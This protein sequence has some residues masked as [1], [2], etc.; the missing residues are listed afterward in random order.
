MEGA[1][2]T[3][4]CESVV[5]PMPIAGPLTAATSGLVKAGTVRIKWAVAFGPRFVLAGDGVVAAL[6]SAPELKK[7]P[8]PVSTAITTRSS[9]SAAVSTSETSS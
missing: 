7:F 2:T 8:A 9:A 4:Q 5:Q 1:R 6:R 3:S